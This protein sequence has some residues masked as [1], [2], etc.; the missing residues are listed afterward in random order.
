MNQTIT[1]QLVPRGPDGIDWDGET[2]EIAAFVDREGPVTRRDIEQVFLLGDNAAL[3]RLNHLRVCGDIR[4][5][6]D[7]RKYYYE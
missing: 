2:R 3:R 4:R 6:R 5:Y 1:G 7:G